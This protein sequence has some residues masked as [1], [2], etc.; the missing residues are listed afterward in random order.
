MSGDTLVYDMASA[1]EGQ[2]SIFVKKDWL[3]ILDNQNGNYAGNQCV[4]DTS[5]L[6]NSNKYMNYREAYLAVPMLLT[7][8]GTALVDPTAAATSAD[9]AFGLKNWFG[10]IVHSFTLDL[11]GTTIIQQTPYVGMWNTFKLMTSFA[12]ADV[13][14]LGPSIG[15]YPD[16][17][18]SVGFASAVSLDG[19]GTFNNRN[20]AGFPSVAGRDFNLDVFAGNDGLRERQKHIVYDA[21]ALA[22]TDAYSTLMTSAAA[23]T[24]YKSYVLSKGVDA[25][26]IAIMAKIQLKHLHS[27]FQSVP[28]LKGVFMKFTLNLN[29]SSVSGTVPGG[30]TLPVPT[31]NS[32]LGG[33]SPIM[34]ASRNAGSVAAASLIHSTSGGNAAIGAGD[35]IVSIAVGNRCLNSAQTGVAGVTTSGL[36]PSVQL[37][38]PAYTFNPVY[39]QAYLSSPVKRIV[40][41]DIYQYQVLNVGAGQQIN[42]L[43]TN[44][45][46]G[47]KSVLVLPFFTTAANAGVNPILSPYDTAGCGTTSPLVMLNNFNVVVSG[48]N[49]IYNT[50]KYSYEQFMN[51]LLGANSV[52]ASLTDG[53][54]SSLISQLDFEHCYCYHWV[55]CSRMLPVEEPVPKSVSIVGTNQSAKAIDLFVF[56]EYGVEISIDVLTGAR[57]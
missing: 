44:G 25:I 27:F 1:S 46:A 50:Q 26:Q 36:N 32:P 55:N 54:D 3:S 13:K 9:T 5:Q 49:M 31:V 30:L 22:G 12:D 52:N 24:L 11:G 56:I 42:N 53:I 47:I 43:I 18:T 38:V 17:A 45:I 40:Y 8:T 39:E 4:I 15:F 57:V 23:A 2:A 28:L 51:Q 6:A 34:I 21:A 16:R 10:S 7:A 14:V 48:Q 41:T 19:I 33:V 35:F 37:Y 20:G 29:Q